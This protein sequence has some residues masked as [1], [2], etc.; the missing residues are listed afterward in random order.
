MQRNAAPTGSSAN[1]Y[2]THGSSIVVGVDLNS[3]Y[4]RRLAGLLALLCLG[5]LVL[6]RKYVATDGALANVADNLIAALLSSIVLLGLA[7]WLLTSSE[8]THELR[9]SEI[10]P[11]LLDGVNATK[12][13]YWF[14]G[15]SG[16]FLTGTVIPKLVK[17]SAGELRTLDM[18]VQMLDPSDAD[19]CEKYADYRRRIKVARE[20]ET[21]RGI[22]L[23]VLGHLISIHVAKSESLL[24]VETYLQ[25]V[26][27]LYRVDLNDD[28]AVI[29]R[30]RKSEP[31][32]KVASS[33]PFFEFLVEDFRLMESQA[34]R[35]PN[36]KKLVSADLS[37]SRIR[38]LVAEWNLQMTLTE[39]EMERV[40][41]HARRP[42]D[43]Y[44]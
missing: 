1:R 24:N 44:A 37:A 19:A 35:L 33:S 27:A 5:I 17:R 23:E 18:R 3:R 31:G 32:I 6:C 13:T 7:M 43:P 20:E 11:T 21:T 38:D 39:A 10:R 16:R 8:G 34:V 41:A 42:L 9:P 25:R 15:R 14:R 30:E 2:I 12:K 36:A 4:R 40:L 28:Y 22:Q 29:T 26:F